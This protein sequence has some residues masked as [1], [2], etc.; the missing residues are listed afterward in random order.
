MAGESAPPHLYRGP[1]GA[2]G[3]AA[4]ARDR[5]YS[6]DRGAHPHQAPGG[7]SGRLTLQG[8]VPSSASLS[9]TACQPGRTTLSKRGPPSPVDCSFA[10]LS[11]SPLRRP[12]VRRPTAEPR[13][14]SESPDACCSAARAAT[15]FLLDRSGSYRRRP[16]EHPGPRDYGSEHQLADLSRSSTPVSGGSLLRGAREATLT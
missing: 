3:R 11:A 12:G 5:G 16:V 8:R 13:R 1:G 4:R 10:S 2:Q 9:T 6:R 14:T 7:R 15:P